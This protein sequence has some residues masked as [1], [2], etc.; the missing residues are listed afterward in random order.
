[1]KR[2]FTL[3][4]QIT[5]SMLVAATLVC[6]GTSEQRPTNAAEQTEEP[7]NDDPYAAALHEYNMMKDPV[8]GIIPAGF[9]Q[10]ELQ[11]VA[12]TYA[13]QKREARNA[14]NLYTQVGPTNLGGRTRSVVYDV[15][16]NGTT[17]RCLL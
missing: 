13:I 1:M 11:Q 16:Y 17:N 15:R 5:F 2:Y 6:C 3:L 7:G 9:R 10:Q 4:W 12:E 8:T 14:S